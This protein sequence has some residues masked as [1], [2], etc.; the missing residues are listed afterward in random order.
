MVLSGDELRKAILTQGFVVVPGVVPLALCKSVVQAICETAGIDQDDN[1]TWYQPGFA[2]LGI[3]ALHHHQA[4]WDLRQYPALYDVFRS[5]YQQDQL[6][7]SMDRV[8]YKPPAGPASADW[9]QHAVHWDCDPWQFEGFDLQGLVYLTDTTADQGAFACV[10]TI[11]RAL[12][13]WRR[14]HLQDANR[15]HPQVADDLLVPVPGPAGALV[16]FHRLM[17]HT[18]LKNLSPRPRFT[19]YVTMSPVG[20]NDARAKRVAEWA[21]R[22]P[23]EWAR[24]QY[25][26]DAPEPGP[27]AELTPLG[28]KLVG[29]DA[30]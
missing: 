19:Q 16:L 9:P 20:N 28:R 2:G 27:L 30:W 7:V 15:R 1:S 29:I 5:V 22:L 8:G 26:T 21:D 14:E 23:P 4:L 3:V 18:N 11:Y 12:D 17:P 10:P 6:W 13:A 24:R 25:G